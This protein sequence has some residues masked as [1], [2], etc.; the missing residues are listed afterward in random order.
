MGLIMQRPRFNVRFVLGCLVGVGALGTG[1]QVLAGLDDHAPPTDGEAGVGA[2]G[3]P[4]GDGASGDA[5]DGGGAVTLGNYV[6]RFDST[7]VRRGGE[8]HVLVHRVD[9]TATTPPLTLHL[10][11]LAD[12]GATAAIANLISPGTDAAAT[13]DLPVDVPSTGE[14]SVSLAVALSAPQVDVAVVASAGGQTQTLTAS[15]IG[16]PGDLD[17]RFGTQGGYLDFSPTGGV[18]YGNHVVVLP[19]GRFFVAGSRGQDAASQL[20]VARFTAN[21]VLD[22]TFGAPTDGG[23]RAGWISFAYGRNTRIAVAPSGEIVVGAASPNNGHLWRLDPNGQPLGTWN[24]DAGIDPGFGISNFLNPPIALLGEAVLVSGGSQDSGAEV[25]IAKYGANGQLDT[26]YGTNGLLRVGVG[27]GAALMQPGGAGAE[28]L[29]VAD[30]GEVWVGGGYYTAGSQIA[31]HSFAM[32][33]QPSAANAG[34]AVSGYTTSLAMQGN[35][36]VGGGT[37]AYT[38]EHMVV[39][40]GR[41]GLDPAFGDGGRQ[42]IMPD[43]GGIAPDVRVDPADESILAVNADY[44]LNTFAVFRLTKD[45]QLDPTFGAAG[46]AAPV[47]GKAYSVATDGRYA[48]AVGVDDN[49]DPLKA[50]IVRYWLH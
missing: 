17:A 48:I 16:L 30:G 2:D 22:T 26:T 20:F 42:V 32:R 11:P 21:G 19:D 44:S 18:F 12:G 4:G 39:Y 7:E 31:Y 15:I 41:N 37:G 9:P 47:A 50:R 28:A 34:E 25:P 8:T 24:G 6:L 5:G 27:G 29:V 46:R 40:R 35:D 38:G 43:A 36:V 10:A 1:C 23:A 45:G 13:A 3:A 33:V 49:T 14:V